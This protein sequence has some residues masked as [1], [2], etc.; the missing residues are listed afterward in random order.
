MIPKSRADSVFA[1]EI[2]LIAHSVD[3]NDADKKKKNLFF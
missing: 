3:L 2:R 1:D